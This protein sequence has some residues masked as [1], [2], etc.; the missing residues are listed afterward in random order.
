M[1][2]TRSGQIFARAVRTAGSGEQ[3]NFIVDWLAAL[4]CHWA[5]PVTLESRSGI[6]HS[7]YFGCDRQSDMKR[8]TPCVVRRGPQ[9]ATMGLD[10]GSADRQA[11]AATL[12]LGC[13]ESAEN[14]VRSSGRQSDARVT[15]GDQH[16]AVVPRFRLHR[17][18]PARVLQWLRWR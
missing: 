5:G 12:G 2:R 8:C 7:H 14:L 11:H 16:S 15:Y 1:D 17:K 3:L 13:K 10:N 4:A 18:L 9:T 6:G